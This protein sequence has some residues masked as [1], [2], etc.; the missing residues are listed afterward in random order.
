MNK[1]PLH[2][3]CQGVVQLAVKCVELLVNI[4]RLEFGRSPS[5]SNPSSPF[6]P[7][8]SLNAR[9]QRLRRRWPLSQS[10]GLRRTRD[11]HR[12][13]RNVRVNLHD[14]RILLRNAAAVDDL[15]NLHAVFLEAIDG[16]SRA[17]AVALDECAVDFRRRRKASA[18]QRS[19]RRWFTRIVRLPLF[20]PARADRIHQAEVS[21]RVE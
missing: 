17:N 3:F 18:Q 13:A 15:L 9:R 1:F 6:G 14:Q 2:S 7:M 20:N 4:V 10:A 8:R 11:F 12:S 19:V 5:A 21:P 16:S